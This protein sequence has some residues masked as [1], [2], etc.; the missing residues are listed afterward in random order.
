MEAG[1]GGTGRA[2]GISGFEVWQIGEDV[3][4][5]VHLATLI[6]LITVVNSGYE[7]FWRVHSSLTKTA[8][9]LSTE[10]LA[11]ANGCRQSSSVYCFL[12][13]IEWKS[14]SVF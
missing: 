6:A 13:Q 12:S 4:S 14:N 3:S 7:S 8:I 9:Q 1:P 5:L 2:V 11:A 10:A